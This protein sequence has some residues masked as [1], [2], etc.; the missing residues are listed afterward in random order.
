VHNLHNTKHGKQCF[1]T[2]EE[3]CRYDFPTCEAEE[4]TVV[5]KGTETNWTRWNGSKT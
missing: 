2:D 5:L 4:T 1:R 3:E